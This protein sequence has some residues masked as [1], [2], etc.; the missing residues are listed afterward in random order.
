MIYA[1]SRNAAGSLCRQIQRG[2][3]EKEYLAVVEGKP[4]KSGDMLRDFLIH[5]RSAGKSR[6]AEKHQKGAKEAGLTYNLVESAEYA[7][8]PVS[9]LRIILH[10]GRTHQIRAQLAHRGLPLLGDGKDGGREKT[11]AFALGS[12]QLRLPEEKTGKKRCFSAPPP[13][14]FPWNLFAG[15][16]VQKE[17]K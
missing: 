11:G 15:N 3:F 2:A 13:D 6:I 5:D 8:K 12:T 16:T 9:L 10:T 4:E 17:E 1:K 7:G 14:A